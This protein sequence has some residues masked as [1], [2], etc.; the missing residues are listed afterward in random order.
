[1]LNN[2]TVL[3]TFFEFAENPYPAKVV[4]EVFFSTFIDKTGVILQFSSKIL[5]VP[6]LKKLPYY[7]SI[8]NK[9]TFP[10]MEKTTL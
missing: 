8:P 9:I 10:I 4:P 6:L 2:S 5:I 1:M 3:D 7:F